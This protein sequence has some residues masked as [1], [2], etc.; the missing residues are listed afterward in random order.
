MYSFSP[1]FSFPAYEV[2]QPEIAMEIP[3]NSH[4][5]PGGLAKLTPSTFHLLKGKDSS[6]IIISS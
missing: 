6:V 2:N 3:R 5:L 4:L 1:S